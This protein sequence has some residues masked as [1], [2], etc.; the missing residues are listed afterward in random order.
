MSPSAAA[1]SVE[2]IGGGY[3]GRELRHAA[4]AAPARW[5][6]GPD[7]CKDTDVQKVK[8]LRW[9]RLHPSRNGFV[10]MVWRKL[11]EMAG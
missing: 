10:A 5:T 2:F 1:S 9:Q 8:S 7:A 4:V 3:D 6:T 11:S